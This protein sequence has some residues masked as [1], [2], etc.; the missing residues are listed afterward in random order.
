MYDILSCDGPGLQAFGLKN[1]RACTSSFPSSLAPVAALN[2]DL[3]CGWSGLPL[4]ADSLCRDQRLSSAHPA[5]LHQASAGAWG[6]QQWDR[7][8]PTFMASQRVC[9]C[10]HPAPPHSALVPLLGSSRQSALCCCVYLLFSSLPIIA[11]S[12]RHVSFSSGDGQD[13]QELGEHVE[14]MNFLG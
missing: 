12:Q 14:M 13:F 3:S 11:D 10:A 4:S 5:R 2:A 1:S 7:P 8:P 9:S 6:G